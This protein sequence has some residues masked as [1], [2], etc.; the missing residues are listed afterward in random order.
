MKGVWGESRPKPIFNPDG[1]LAVPDPSKGGVAQWRTRRQRDLDRIRA[2]EDRLYEQ[3]LAILSAGSHGSTEYDDDE[4]LAWATDPGARSVT[5]EDIKTHG[6]IKAALRYKRVALDGRRSRKNAPVYFEN[7]KAITV[8]IAKQ[9]A[10]D[11]KMGQG[12]EGGPTVNVFINNQTINNAERYDEIE[13]VDEK[14]E[15]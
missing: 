4:A 12:A 14:D 15:P 10:A 13:V 5:P 1:T 2:I 3:S 8:A 11:G 7:A 9:R 6:S